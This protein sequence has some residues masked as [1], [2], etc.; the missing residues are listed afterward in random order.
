MHAPAGLL[1]LLTAGLLAAADSHSADTRTRP[2]LDTAKLDRTLNEVLADWPAPGAAIAVVIDGEVVFQKG[3]GLRRLDAADPVTPRSLFAIGSNTKAFT[4]A[5]LGTLV[6]EGRLHWDDP[7][8]DHLPAFRL[9]D[10]Y[11]TRQVTVRD[12]LTHRTGLPKYGGDHLWI[13][14]LLS[15]DEILRRLR[16]LQPS[17]GLREKV[18]YNNLLWMVAG[19]IYHGI[20]GESWA[21]GVRRRLFEPLKMRDSV[22]LVGELDASADIAW[23]HE[24]ID[25]ELV[26]LDFENIDVIAAAGSVLSS[27]ADMT[28]WLAMHLAD[29]M[30]GDRRVL[31]A[32]T[33]RDLHEFVMPAPLDD[34]IEILSGGRWFGYGL[35]WR[36]FDY[37]HHRVLRHGGS[38]TGM[39]A[40]VGLVP[41]RKAGIVVL[42]NYAPGNLREALLMT[43]LDHLLGGEPA[44]WSTRL[45]ALDAAAA[46]ERRREL[47]A[48]RAARVAGTAPGLPL[49]Q[50]GGH[51][52]S[53]LSGSASVEAVGDELRFF[54]N[55]RHQGTMTHWHYDV[56]RVVWDEP[57]YDAPRVTLARFGLGADGRVERLDIRLYSDAVTFLRSPPQAP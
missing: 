24:H 22:A 36:V 1:F 11:L 48:M 31:A 25:G 8:I 16:Y 10:P 51:Y 35:G 29:G 44:D 56:F 40:Q 17:A 15:R 4:A 9:A 50:Y 14:G 38:I 39:K 12:L 30:S 46:D 37:K 52:F 53:E 5:L 13:G 7:V 20:T 18:Q 23:P 27:A 57:L 28:R 2:T 33:V 6:D 21:D 47:D 41:D 54:Y 45:L 26:A 32:G 42:T 34:E 55:D 3:Y 19:E 43:V 49:A